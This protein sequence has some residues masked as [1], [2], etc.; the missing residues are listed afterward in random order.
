MIGK[1][2]ITRTGYDPAKGRETIDPTLEPGYQHPEYPPITLGECDAF[3]HHA[4]NNGLFDPDGEGAR[5]SL[6]QPYDLVRFCHT[7]R[8]L[9]A[10]QAVVEP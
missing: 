8:Q 9:R 2:H 7:V 5:Y 6:I 4:T 10:A 3:E 1:V